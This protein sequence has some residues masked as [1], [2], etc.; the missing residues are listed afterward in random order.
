LNKADG[1]NRQFI[2]IEMND[3][4]ETIT[5]ERVRRVIEGYGN[6]EGTGGS[7]DFYTLGEALFDEQGN[8]NAQAKIEAI[9]E[10][11]WFTETRRPAPPAPDGGAKKESS[12][13]PLLG[14]EGAFLG[15]HNET[16]YYFCYHPNQAIILDMDLLATITRKA[17]QYLIYADSCELSEEFLNANN[18][19]FKKIPRDITR[20]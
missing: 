18:I 20:L 4:A 16:D 19:I 9:R 13:V 5:A 8:L 15:T 1:R 6:T 7:F 14:A 3:Y 17:P 11:I 12:E 2:L 10:Y